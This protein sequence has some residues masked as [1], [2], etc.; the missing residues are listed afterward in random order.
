MPD[1]IGRDPHDALAVLNQLGLTRVRVD[2][3]AGG[4]GILTVIGQ[5]PSAGTGMRLTDRVVLRVG[6]RQ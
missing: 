5:Q 1:V 4:A 3:S 2:S 6:S